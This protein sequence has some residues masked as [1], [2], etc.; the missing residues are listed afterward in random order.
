MER[1]DR[2]LLRS[3]RPAR[4]HLAVTVV[5]GCLSAALVVAQAALIARVVTRVFIDGDGPSEVRA[6]LVV[7]AGVA[8][9]RGL[10]VAG[11]EASGRLGA[12]RAMSQLR[13]DLAAHVLR[14]RPAGLRR[15]RAGELVAAAVQGVDALEA[16]FARWL[17]QVVL[18]VIVPLAILAFVVPRDLA[19]AIVLLVTIPVVPVFM[20]L[21]GLAARGKARRRFGALARLSGHLLDVVRGLP[22]LRANAREGAQERTLAG[23][24]EAYRR[25]TMGTLRVAFLSSLVLELAAA[26]ATALVAATVGIQLAEGHLG[27]EAG[28]TVLLLAP[29]LYLPLRR[30]GAEW[31]ASA[32]G[33]AAAE[34]LYAA[35]DEPPGVRAPARPVPA[36]DPRVAAVTFESVGFGWPGRGEPALDG[37]D[38]TLEPRRTVALVG[39]SGAG[40]STLAALLLRL[41]E[42]EAGAVRCGGV[43]LRDVDAAAWRARVAWVPQSPTIFAATLLDNLRLAAPRASAA[44]ARRALGGVGLTPLLD[45]LPEGLETR[46]GE[47]GRALSAGEAQRVGL[48]RA[49]LADRPLIVLDEPTAHLDGASAARAD[50]AIARAVA[51]RTA[52]LIAHR[53]A[54]AARADRVVTMA[55]GRLRALP[56]GAAA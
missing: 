9:A 39:P 11:M 7:L 13:C 48:A 4:A 23:V 44:A 31:H 3:S 22:A 42:P 52:L 2:R 6:T 56:A 46:V 1:V 18:S 51:G 24:G 40:K 20:V 8:V 19:A 41:V 15:E 33:L 14:G 5:L 34:A 26:L 50:A 37:V 53:P 21:V 28:L 32:D 29:E 49:L 43:D 36:P 47:G 30:L 25:E 12:S 35:L 54:L 17:P 45:A 55:G 10:V 38:L 16:W 27:L